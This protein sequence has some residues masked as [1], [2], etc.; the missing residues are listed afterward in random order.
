MTL[1]EWDKVNHWLRKEAT[2][3]EEISGLL[4]KAERNLLQAAKRGIDEDWRLLMAFTAALL[5]PP[6]RCGR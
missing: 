5:A 4:R 2:S 6:S 3:P 1:E